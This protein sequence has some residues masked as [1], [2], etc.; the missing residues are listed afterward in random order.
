[1]ETKFELL[2]IKDLHLTAVQFDSTLTYLYTGK[3]KNNSSSRYLPKLLT[4]CQKLVPYVNFYKKQIGYY[5]CTAYE[6][7]ANEIGMILL[8]F[9][10]DKRHKRGI[11][12]LL[13]VVLL[14]WHMKVFLVFC[15]TNIKRLYKRQ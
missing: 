12:G 14:V 2:K 11:I 15:I 1:M 5:N 9:P 7:L 3:D 10:K 13:S 6:M 8:T 4:F